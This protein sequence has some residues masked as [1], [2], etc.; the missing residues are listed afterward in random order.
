MPLKQLTVLATIFFLLINNSSAQ[1]FSVAELKKDLE[2]IEHQVF[3][4]QANPFRE[5]TKKQYT[6]QFDHIRSRLKDSLTTAQF[7]RMV[8]PLLSWISDE[9]AAISLPENINAFDD[10][11]LLLPFSLK[12]QGDFFV[13][14]T[15]L[16]AVSGISKGVVISKINHVNIETLVK[17]CAAFTTGFPAQRLQKSA[18]YFGYLYGLVKGPLPVYT[19]TLQNGRDITVPGILATVWDRFINETRDIAGICSQKISYV[20][21]GKFGYINACSFSTRNDGEFAEVRRAIDSIFLQVQKD[22]VTDLVIDVS[23]N[24]GGNSEVGDL[25]IAGFYDKPYRTYQCNWK[26]SDEYLSVIKSWG[27][28]DEQYERLRPGEI[29]YYASDTVTPPVNVNRYKGKVYVL[30]G[31]DTFSSAIMFATIIKDNAIATLVGQTPAD[32]HPNHFGEMYSV[33]TPHTHLGI[34]FGVKEWIRPAGKNADNILT[35][36]I[37]ARLPQSLDV[38]ALVDSIGKSF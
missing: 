29:L 34:R 31:E 27:V 19:I 5:L 2:F 9:H 33:K 38:K 22:E 10:R 30:I 14:D 16:A 18:R 20:N 37:P 8:K 15:L 6:Q 4:V 7:Y 28:H 11:V 21:N 26:R 1:K 13:A 12:R 23:R 24:S 17:E 35:P 25:L 36:D 32:G 3:V